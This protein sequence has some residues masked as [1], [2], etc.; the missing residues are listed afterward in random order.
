MARSNKSLNLN[1]KRRSRILVILST[2]LLCLFA[3]LPVSENTSSQTLSSLLVGEVLLDESFEN[4]DRWTLGGTHARCYDNWYNRNM[5]VSTEYDFAQRSGNKIAEALGCTYYGE[6]HLISPIMD[7]STHATINIEFERY[8]HSNFGP[9]D[10]LSLEAK[11]SNG[12]WIT[13]AT[14]RDEQGDDSSWHRELFTLTDSRYFHPGFQIRF[15]YRGKGT[16]K[17]YAGIDDLMIVAGDWDSYP[18]RVMAVGC[19][20]MTSDIKQGRQSLL[21]AIQHSENGGPD[22]A[23]AFDWDTMLNLGDLVG[24]QRPPTDTDAS[25]VLEQ[26]SS[27]L[28]HPREVIYNVAGNHDA[29]GPGEETQWWFRKYIDPTGENT[30]FSGVDDST[31]PYPVEGTWERYAFQVGNILFLMMSDRNDG[32]PSV[33]RGSRGGYPAGAVTTETFDWWRQMVESNQDKIIITGHHHV[34]R[35]TTVASDLGEGTQ[36]ATWPEGPQRPYHGSYSQGAPEGSSFLYFTDGT[37]NAG[38]FEAYLEQHP[39]AISLWL[40][41]HTHTYPEDEGPGGAFSRKTHI[42]QKWGVTFINVSGLTLHHGARQKF[43]LSRLLS[44]TPGEAEVRIQCYLHTDHYAQPGWYT[45]V[46]QYVPLQ[47]PFAWDGQ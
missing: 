3:N 20:H 11:D 4:F 2:L 13:R 30:A 5:Y 42:E 26:L 39:G 14:W 21:E 34:L 16:A 12:D 31:R 22:G 19:A 17:D 36:I 1:K 41:A 9:G 47:W 15:T 7:T 32:G 33:G 35:N 18:F 45:P 44:F 24:G 6:A 27:S 37:S 10:H 25:T 38:L 40:G 23:P 46:E 29:S 8:V 28:L 43:P